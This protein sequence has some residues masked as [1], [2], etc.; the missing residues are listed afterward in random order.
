MSDTA[1]WTT[2]RVLQEREAVLRRLSQAQKMV[3]P[4]VV[5]DAL[6]GADTI[7]DLRKAIL[8]LTKSAPGIERT[9]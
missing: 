6:R 1:L 9:D 5:R 4:N 7:A 8:R 3:T 2:L